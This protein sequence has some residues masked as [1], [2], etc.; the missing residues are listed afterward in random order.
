MNFIFKEIIYVLDEL[1]IF[2]KI[3]Y[4]KIVYYIYQELIKCL[5][6]NF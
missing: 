6:E 5:M 1:G 3:Y 2:E 4:L